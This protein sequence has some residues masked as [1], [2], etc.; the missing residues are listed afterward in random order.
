M[1]YTVSTTVEWPLQ[2]GLSIAVDVCIYYEM[3]KPEPESL[4]CPGSPGGP[5]NYQSRLKF[6]EVYDAAQKSID[7]ELSKEDETK[8]LLTATSRLLVDQAWLRALCIEDYEQNHAS[9]V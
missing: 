8:I 6:V 2:Y 7:I 3:E 1:S 9:R 4:D 5:T